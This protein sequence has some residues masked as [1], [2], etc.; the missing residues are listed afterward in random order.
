MF[1][2]KV[3]VFLN[4]LEEDIDALNGIDPLFLR[5]ETRLR[6]I[7]DLQGTMAVSDV[8]LKI[9]IDSDNTP[10]SRLLF[11]KGEMILVE[12]HIPRKGQQV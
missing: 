6:V 4:L 1:Y 7:A 3:V 12:Q 5:K 2:A 8:T 10:F 9:E 11:A